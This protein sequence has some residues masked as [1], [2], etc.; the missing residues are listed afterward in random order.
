MHYIVYISVVGLYRRF[1]FGDAQ[2]SPKVV[3]RDRVLIDATPSARK[4]GARLGMSLTEAK[5]TLS[6]IEVI[7]WN[8][9]HDDEALESWMAVLSE[10]TD[11][12]EVGDPHSAFLDLTAHPDPMG[13][14]QTML[15]KLVLPCRVG[16]GASK[17]I[18]RATARDPQYGLPS[19][20]FVVRP[21]KALRT[22]PTEVLPI[23]EDC[24]ARLGFLGYR[25][26]SDVQQATLEVLK[27]QFGPIGS[28]VY[29]SSRGGIIQLVEPDY[30]R[31]TIGCRHYLAAPWETVEHRDE[32]LRRMAAMLAKPL[33]DA[34]QA[35]RTLTL[36]LVSED[37]AKLES[38][39]IFSRPLRTG[40]QIFTA[41]QSACG[42][43]PIQAI[44]V[45][46]RLTE[47]ESSR[48][49]QYELAQLRADSPTETMRDAI[50]NV[51]AAFG[52]NAVVA[53]ADWKQPRRQLVLK[54]WKDATG[55]V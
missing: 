31:S 40:H 38:E 12:I 11:R 18:A 27:K 23:P 1:L 9:D 33:V 7:E 52:S 41:L 3:H 37:G 15:D 42:V 50:E 44:E 51:Q 16:L 4:L 19:V 36:T 28:I 10:F 35:A 48:A 46:A 2:D 39:R 24:V 47:L 55:W 17:W 29:Q 43:E 13:I 20:D 26:I 8:P 22:Y 14:I 25:K 45:R 54:A 32:D 6:G 34:D 21:A 5:S 30:P 49:R 53:A